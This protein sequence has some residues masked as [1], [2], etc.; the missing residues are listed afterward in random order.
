MKINPFVAIENELTNIDDILEKTLED[1]QVQRVDI[2]KK[3]EEKNIK[4][5][6]FGAYNAGKS[7]LINTILGEGKAKIGDIPT[8]D[9]I[10]TYKWNDYKLLDT[11]GIN[12]PIEHETI[13]KTQL[14]KS[15]LIVF[16]IRKDDEDASSTDWPVDSANFLTASQEPTSHCPFAVPISA[17]VPASPTAPEAIDS[18]ILLLAERKM[19]ASPL[20]V[21]L[22]I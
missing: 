7:T 8:T 2:S 9:A 18:A 1:Y 10:D 17:L 22:V 21:S 4:I 14:E 13:S 5:M 6:F 12:A 19:S 3:L 16:V 11:P 20:P 15:D